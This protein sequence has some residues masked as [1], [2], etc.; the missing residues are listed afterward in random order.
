VGVWI[1]PPAPSAT[2]T[3]DDVQGAE[4]DTIT[5]SNVTLA[6]QVL[7]VVP[8]G[9][10][11][12]LEADYSIFDCICPTCS[13]QIQVGFVPGRKLACAYDGVPNQSSPCMTPVTDHA[14]RTLPVPTTPGVYDLRFRLGQDLGC[15]S[16]GTWWTDTAPGPAQ[17]VA[18]ICVQ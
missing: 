15:T 10:Q 6:G 12:T 17:T 18:T 11:L 7:A 5:L 1:Q 2:V 4:H 9:A 14:T 3:L 13:D 16:G 8:A